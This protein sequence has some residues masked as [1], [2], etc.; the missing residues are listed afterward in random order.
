[1][2]LNSADKVF[3]ELIGQCV[4]RYT[5]GGET[6]MGHI[7][8][9]VLDVIQGTFFPHE[10]THLPTHLPELTEISQLSEI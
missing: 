6:V 5:A 8:M 2:H 9:L 4:C 10:C 7:V 3:V 1:M